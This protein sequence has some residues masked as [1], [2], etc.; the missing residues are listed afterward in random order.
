MLGD[1]RREM[2]ALAAPFFSKVL[3]RQL[4]S[5]ER[6]K[7]ALLAK[8]EGPPTEP[9]EKKAEEVVVDEE[10]PTLDIEDLQPA[11]DVFEAHYKLI[12]YTCAIL[13]LLVGGACGLLARR[14]HRVEV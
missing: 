1:M 9:P 13:A 6:R 2:H 10:E 11:Q 4:R 8:I 7:K 3:K 14:R 12:M 5:L